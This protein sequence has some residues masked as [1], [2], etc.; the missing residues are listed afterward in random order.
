M[1]VKKVE[2][3]LVVGGGTAGWLTAGIIAAKHGTSVSI[4]VVESPNIKTV[5]VGEGTWP[6]MKTTLQE[7]GVSET[8]FLRQCDASFKQGAKFCQWKTGEQSDYYYHP[9]MLPRDFDEFN[10]APFWLDQKSGESFSNSVCFQQ[11]LCEKNLA[12][13]TLTMPEYAGAANY[14]YHLDAGKFAPF[15]THHCTKKLNVTHVKA[16]VENVKLTDSGE[17]D[18]LLTKEA[19]QLEADLYIDCSG[20][21]S[22]LLGQALD[23][24]FVDKS[25]ILFLDTA[26]ATHVPYPTENSAIAP[27][28]LSTAQTSGWI[29]DIGLQSRRGVGHV[30]SSKYIDDQTAKQQLADYLCTDVQSLET[31][32]IPM[33][34]GHREKFWQKNCVAIGLA[35]G[36]LEPLEAS[37]LVLVEMSAQFIRDQLPAHTS[38]M[39]IVEK[40]FNTTFHYRWQRIIDFLKLHYVLSQRRDSEFW[41][42]QQDACSIPESLQELLN[43]WQYQPP[44]RHDFLHKDEVF[45][46]ASYQYVL[47]GM[48]FKTHC[49]EDEVN[50][51]RYQQLLEETSFTKHRAIK[52]LPPTRELLNTLHQHR[53]Q[54]I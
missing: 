47:Y 2:S 35:A 53:M 37:A 17:I 30:Y 15:L 33:P 14:A 28:T 13:K 8:D 11:A 6:T 29:W 20:F 31:K 41:C 52:A 24:P 4:T 1:K 16:T 49:R 34:C 54:V 19:G 22:L 27:H 45:P 36:F 9:L 25:D 32:T 44:W 46:A 3:I 26:I 48:G 39:P 40:R 12:P 50:K 51:A 23:V 10:S 18:Y 5:G 42:A 7:M 43:L 38:I 21:C